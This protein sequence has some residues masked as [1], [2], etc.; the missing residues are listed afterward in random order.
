[1][2]AP[3]GPEQAPPPEHAP[4]P[5]GQ[6]LDGGSVSIFVALCAVGLL[7]VIGIVIDCGGRLRAVERADA[8]AQEAARAAGQRIDPAAVLTGGPVIVSPAAARAAAKDYLA[9]NGVRGEAVVDTGGRTI[10]VTVDGTYETALLGVIGIGSM[11]VHGVGSAGLVYGV[12]G[13]ENG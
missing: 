8:L 10:H 1:M 13:A 3:T 2:C 7:I 12:Q 11:T 6:P 9:V 5:G 4:P